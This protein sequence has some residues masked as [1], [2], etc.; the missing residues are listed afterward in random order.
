[1]SNQFYLV[2]PALLWLLA[3]KGNRSRQ[4]LVV[5]AIGLASFGLNHY[6]VSGNFDE[7]YASTI[8]FLTPFRMFE[9]AIG[10]LGVFLAPV[11]PKKRWLH[12][13]LML[14]GLALIAFSVFS[15]TEES[16][17]PYLHALPPC[18]GALLVILGRESR[19]AGYLLTNQP[20]V[21]IGLVSYSVYLVHWPVLVL[22]KYHT[23]E[24]VAGFEAIGL[25]CLT[26]LLA[27]AQYYFVEKRYRRY[28]PGG[29]SHAPQRKFVLGSVAA[30]LSVGCIG[31]VLSISEVSAWGGKGVLTVAEITAGKQRR[32]DLFRAGC[33]LDRAGHA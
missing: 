33:N 14:T 7:D 22:Y 13:L 10:A 19:R 5:L 26:M 30:L 20:A 29:A 16:L 8:F 1:M 11:V 4:L 9:L 15:Y 32:N 17:L 6:W 18:I 27:A 12:E 2:W 24:E 3:R 25:I 28:P 23:L 21:W 31:F